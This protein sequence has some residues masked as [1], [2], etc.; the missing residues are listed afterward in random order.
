MLEALYKKRKKGRFDALMYIVIAIFVILVTRLF[1]LQIVE[2]EYYHSKAEGNRLRMLSVT[3]ARGIMYDRNGQILVGSRPAYTVSIMPTDKEID[4]S[5]LQR[6]AG[7]LGMKPE[8]IKEK[9]KA[10]EGGYEPIRLANDITMDTVTKIAERSH[11]LP[12]VSIDVEPLRYYPYDTMASQ[13]FGYVGEVGEEELADIREKDPNTRVGPGT[14]LGR[15]G[16]ERMYDNVLRGID[17]GKQVE[18]DAAGRPVAEVGRQNTVPGRDIHLTIDLPLQKAAEKAVADQ[19][20]SLRSQ[21]I[22][23][24]G[25]AV[26]AMDPNTGAILA[27]VSAPEFNPNWFAR[28]ITSAQWKQLNTDMNHPFD[29]KVVSGEYPPGSPFKIITGA[30]AL[31]LKKV[32]PDE[33]IFDSGRHWLIDKR[34]AEGEA[35][36]WLDFNTALAKSDNVY[37]Y[38]MGNRVGIENL[39][40]FARLF[41]LGEKT[42]I[43]L[44]GEAAGNIASPEY[45]RKV[46]DQDWYLGETFD[47]AIGQSFTLV[48]PIQ[49]AMVMSE[50]ANGGIRYQPYVVSRID[51]SD[52]TPEEIFGPKKIGVLQISKSVMDLIRNALR[53]VTA[54]GGT[55]G[56]LFKDLPIA[57]AGKT[58][59]AENATG[60]DH[61]WFVAYA[62]YDK[63][64]IVVVALVEQGSF[65]AGSAG[66][67]VR[68][69]LEE[70]FHV[71]QKSQTKADDG[72]TKATEVIKASKPAIT[73]P[74]MR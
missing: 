47:A 17:G 6:L 53:D 71:G 42:G 11:E 35:L 29:N 16:L 57:V 23:A 49:M 31:E 44:F 54:E 68:A 13:L 62:P 64:R 66:P 50:V 56:S 5:E 3:A 9:V 61:G 43:K 7:I 37:F 18:V 73:G 39:D 63:P 30:A 58:G 34:N 28:G 25:A 8:A 10:H 27:M 2:G 1:Y 12:G 67:I 60:R 55:A 21:G 32:T 70:Y 36:G 24:K 26:V 72:N 19:L 41:G 33:M 15:A 22:P 69:V 59:T 14:I 48:T 46:F 4:D 52:G 74:Q 51:N 65:G 38:E 40:K 45:K 20:A